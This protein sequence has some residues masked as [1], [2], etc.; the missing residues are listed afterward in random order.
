MLWKRKWPKISLKWFLRVW[1]PWLVFWSLSFHLLDFADT[2]SKSCIHILWIQIQNFEFV[3]NPRSYGYDFWNLYPIWNSLDTIFFNFCIQI[4]N[5]PR[6]YNKLKSKSTSIQLL[7]KIK[8]NPVDV[9]FLKI[10]IQ[11][12]R[13]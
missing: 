13:P 7:N 1:K 4:Q 3:S 9:S 12:C 2:F 6:Y 11:R 10:R 5:Y 8:H